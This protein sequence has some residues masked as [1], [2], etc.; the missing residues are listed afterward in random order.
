MTIICAR[1][2]ERRPHEARGL[3]HTCYVKVRALGMLDAYPKG[4][5]APPAQRR[6]TYWRE[7]DARRKPYFDALYARRKE[8]RHGPT[9]R[10]L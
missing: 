6:A 5:R 2:G 9:T 1:C 4:R 8:E 10:P 7:R 3:C